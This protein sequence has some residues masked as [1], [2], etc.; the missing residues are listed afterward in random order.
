MRVIGL[1]GGIASGKSSVALLL[2]KQGIPVI[3]AD[4]LARDAVLPGTHALQQIVAFFGAQMLNPAGS[5]NRTALA[6]VIFADPDARRTLEAI[7]HPAIKILA[8]Q[9]LV[10]LQERGEAVVV[11]MAPLLIEAGATGRVDEIWVVYV[12]RETQLQR[13]MTRDGVSRENAVKRLAAQMPMQDKAA[14]GRIVIDNCGTAE[15]LEKT[16]NELCRKEFGGAQQ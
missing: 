12:D 8:E 1:T 7:M 4:Q 16:I 9:R 3:D 5:L 15:T 2:E 13:L 11:Y 14:Y 6:E 10:E